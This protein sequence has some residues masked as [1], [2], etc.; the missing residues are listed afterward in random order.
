MA[1]LVT[2]ATGFI[3]QWVLDCLLKE[4]YQVIGTVRSQEKGDKLHKQFGSPSKL[5]FEIV[6][7]ISDT[8]AF[9][10]LFKKRGKEI[11]IVL[12][13][14][15]PCHFNTSDYEKDLLIPALNG[16]KGVLNAIKKYG[17]VK[18]VVV[19]SS[20]A[21]IT[22]MVNSADGSLVF[23][24]KDW[25][26][27]TWERCQTDAVNAYCASKK[28]AEQAAWEFSKETGVSLTTIN[29]VFVFGPQKFDEDVTSQLNTSNE[30]INGLIHSKPGDKLEPDYHSAYVDVRDVARAHL[31]AFQ[32]DTTGERLGLSN[33]A[34]NC[35]SILDILNE[36]FPQ[37][38]N[39][40]GPEPGMGD[41]K[42][43]AVFDNRHSKEVLAFPFI[44]LEQCVYDTVA[45]VLKKEGR[46]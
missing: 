41:T 5:S 23:T 21:A 42:P 29:P 3:A 46:L 4:N 11:D 33:G 43:G 15:S 44:S 10:P 26:P 2:G 16:T 22:D 14:A 17:D 38:D 35:Q 19:T 45:Q 36:K 31:V 25:N 9:E 32:K 34:F 28:F 20:Y 39:T 30:I 7:D 24:E 37:L 12:H 13:M 8:E 18:K 40:K 6:K 1:V 27:A